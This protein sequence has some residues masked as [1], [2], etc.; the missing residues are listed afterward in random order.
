MLQ[1][2]HGWRNADVWA[3]VFTGARDTWKSLEYGK[4]GLHSRRGNVSCS[5]GVFLDKIANAAKINLNRKIKKKTLFLL[6]ENSNYFDE[7]DRNNLKDEFQNYLIKE[8]K[9]KS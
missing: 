4:A 5:R 3:G 1:Y 2:I 8:I 9:N 6:G 7:V